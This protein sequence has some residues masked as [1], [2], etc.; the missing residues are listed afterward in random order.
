[1]SYYVDPP[2]PFSKTHPEASALLVDLVKENARRTHAGTPRM[3]CKLGQSIIL[4]SSKNK[5][6]RNDPC[7]CKSGIKYKKCCGEIAIFCV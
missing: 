3:V 1:M 4:E 2:I 7:P 6:G 5:I